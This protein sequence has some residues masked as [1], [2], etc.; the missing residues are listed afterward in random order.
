M[1]VMD[2]INLLKKYNMYNDA[3]IECKRLKIDKAP[4]DMQG[5]H[6][7]YCRYL[8][9]K[10]VEIRN[11]KE[12]LQKVKCHEWDNI[13]ENS[14]PAHDDCFFVNISLSQSIC[15]KLCKYYQDNIEPLEQAMAELSEA[16]K[17]LKEAAQK[18]FYLR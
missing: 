18:D 2:A 7:V 10:W 9:K 3:E 13:M 14:K 1:D 5:Y 11:K 8:S 16:Q 15:K 17:V 4:Y 6:E 12:M